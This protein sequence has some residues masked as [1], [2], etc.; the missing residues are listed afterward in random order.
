MKLRK[1]LRK[2]KSKAIKLAL[3]HRPMEAVFT[4]IYA[5]NSWGHAESVSGHGSALEKTVNVRRRLPQLLRDYSVKSLLDI[6]CGDFNWMKTVDLSGIHY[7]GGDIVRGL[8]KQNRENYGSA[9]REFID[10]DVTTMPVPA[11]DLILCRDLLVHLPTAECR[12]VLAAFIDSG[13]TYLLTTTYLHQPENG[14]IKP[15][16]WRPVNLQVAPFFFPEPLELI[17]D[18]DTDAGEQD[19]GKHLALWRISDLADGSTAD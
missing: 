12:K 17:E 15:G 6:P 14:D 1:K 18:G 11:V 4:Y 5:N 10:I 8:I 9:D 3:A 19:Y 13:S 16:K 7:T 2:I